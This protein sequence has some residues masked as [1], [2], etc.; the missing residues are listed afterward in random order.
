MFAGI[1]DLYPAIGFNTAWALVILYLG[2]ALGGSTWL[3]KGFFDTV[4][5]DLDESAKVDGATHVQ[6]YFGIILPLVTPILAVTGLVSF[7]GA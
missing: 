4:P 3:I 1:S 6:I 5:K 2:G 7:I